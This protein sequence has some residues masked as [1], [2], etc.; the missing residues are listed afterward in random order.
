MKLKV[1]WLSALMAMGLLCAACWEPT[2]REFRWELLDGREEAR[3]ELY[4]SSEK[5]ADTALG[6]IRRAVAAI[7][8]NMLSG[9]DSGSLGLLNRGAADKYTPVEDRDLYRCTLLALDY[10]R[11]SD[12]AFDPTV[13]ALLNLYDAHSP[14]QPPARALELALERVGWQ[15]VSVADEARS[16]RFRRPGMHLDLGGVAKGFALDA[17]ARAFT[18]PGNLAG[19]LRIGGNFYAWGEPPGEESWSVALPDP[20]SPGR[21]LLTIQ[22]ANRGVAV[23]GHRQPGPGE[24]LVLD[25]AT[26]LPAAGDLLAAVAVADSAGDADA[27]STALFVSG[28]MRGAELLGKM[29]RAEAVLL[30]AG[31]GGSAYLLAS[32]SLRG[33]LVPSPELMAETEGDIRYLL[34][35]SSL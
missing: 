5:D 31:E 26:G 20:R 13:G 25:P 34:P 4:T 32:V 10:A 7:E 23:T 33:R 12:G 35:P 2:A 22:L 29:N 9:R 14:A 1:A 17:A 3:V 27:L 18:R 24:R 30:V 19:L 21:S 6:E 8:A 16:I 28:S 15:Q 11:A